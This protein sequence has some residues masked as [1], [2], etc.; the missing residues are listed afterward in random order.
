MAATIEFIP[1]DRIKHLTSEERI[2]LIVEKA[3]KDTVIITDGKLDAK[4]T[5]SLIQETMKNVSDDFPGI[6]V[7]S[8]DYNELQEQHSSEV[9]GTSAEASTKG[10]KTVVSS[11]IKGARKLMAQVYDKLRFKMTGRRPGVTIVGPANIVKEIKRSPDK[12]SLLME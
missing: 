5:A 9:T 7:C 12:I 1:F 4:E 11:S 8:I 3:K 10:A 2:K 6:E